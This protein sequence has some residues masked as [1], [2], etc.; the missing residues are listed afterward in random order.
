MIQGIVGFVLDCRDAQSLAD[1]Y[2]KLLGWEKVFSNDGWTGLK[3]PQGWTLAF[4]EIEGYVAPVWPWEPNSQQ[5]QAHMDFQVEDL[6]AAVMFAIECG[7][8]K[9]DVQ[10]YETSVTMF[11][12][13]GHPFCLCTAN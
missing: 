13:Q 3:S 6:E 2:V 4:Q 5:P 12:P 11:D 8:T 1:F 10:Y 7:A 9:S